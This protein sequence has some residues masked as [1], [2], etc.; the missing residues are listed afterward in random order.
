MKPIKLL[1][2]IS[3]LAFA[4]SIQSQNII[5]NA[6]FLY[7]TFNNNT[8]GEKVSIEKIQK[9]NPLSNRYT[10]NTE[11]IAENNNLIYYF[12]GKDSVLYYNYDLNAGDTFFFKRTMGID[13]MFVDSVKLI[14]L[15]DNK[16]YKHWYLKSL[17]T[18]NPIVWVRGLG[19]KKLAWLRYDLQ[20]I[21]TPK[22]KA[23]CKNDSLIFWDN[24]F[25]GFEPRNVQATCEFDSLLKRNSLTAIDFSSFVVFPNPV[26]N[27]IQVNG[28]ERGPYKIYNSIGQLQQSGNFENSI[29]IENLKTG[30][31]FIEIEQNNFNLRGSFLKE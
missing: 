29:Q 14:L 13:T 19:E 17:Y 28:I 11:T 23:I 26:S 4:T 21:N 7:L 9:I 5:D 10:F 8:G 15:N 2:I 12:N 22:L 24:S 6:R 18:S 30:L 1:F 16:A 27:S 3:L 25:N 20:F 31:Y